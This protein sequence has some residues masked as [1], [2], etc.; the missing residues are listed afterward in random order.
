MLKACL[1]RL[2]DAA[3][4]VTVDA[5]S[6]SPEICATA[7]RWRIRAVGV[8]RIT[9]LIRLSEKR[10]I[11]SRWGYFTSLA[12]CRSVRPQAVDLLISA[13]TER[14]PAAILSR[15]VCSAA[16]LAYSGRSFRKGAGASGLIRPFTPTLM[17]E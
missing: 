14:R 7:T 4:A 5:L 1:T 17:Q 2:D 6:S 11:V 10:R 16:Q 15:R 8:N 3:V 9:R 13:R 12:V